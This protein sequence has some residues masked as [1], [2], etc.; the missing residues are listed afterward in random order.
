MNLKIKNEKEVKISARIAGLIG[1]IVLTTGS[2]AYTVSA[3]IIDYNDSLITAENF[4][5]FES[6]FRLG[7]VSGLLMQVIFIFYAIALYRLLSPINKLMSTLMMIFVLIPIPIFL[8]NQLNQFEGFLFAQNQMNDNMMTALQLH[9]QGGYIVSIFYGLWLFPL[10]YLIFKSGFL[11]K[12]L[13]I[14][15][16]IGCLGYL[17]SFIQGYLFPNLVNTL[18]TNPFLVFTHISEI[19]LMLWLI[20]M[21]VNK[22]KWIRKMKEI[23]S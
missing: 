16:M 20:V 13:G 12:L 21:G 2:Y 18:W 5:N 6:T 3:K 17:I 15:L 9:K 22:E 1:L 7:F 11:P 8:I 19:L 10:G 4:I 23:E 14:L